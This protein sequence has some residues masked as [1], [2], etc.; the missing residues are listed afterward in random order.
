MG[1]FDILLLQTPQD[2]LETALEA[3]AGNCFA[4]PG[5]LPGAPG[6]PL[7]LPLVDTLGK[8]LHHGLELSE[9][10]GPSLP[11]LLHYHHPEPEVEAA[12]VGRLGWPGNAGEEHLE[13]CQGLQGSCQRKLPG[14]PKENPE[15]SRALKYQNVP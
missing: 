9:G 15:G 2:L 6:S 1:H 12:H 3:G 5:T 7:H 10:G 11:H 8:G 14:Q 4:G 13:S